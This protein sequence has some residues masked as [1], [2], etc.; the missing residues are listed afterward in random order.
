VLLELMPGRRWVALLTA[1]LVF[2]HPTLFILVYENLAQVMLYAVFVVGA[3]LCFVRIE[4][5]QRPVA[6]AV[7]AVLLYAGALTCREQSFALPGLFVGWWALGLLFQREFTRPRKLQGA[8]IAASAVL[9]A[10][11]W[12]LHIVTMK[13]FTG[14]YRNVFDAQAVLRNLTVLPQ[15]L[16]RW[17]GSEQS[18][19]LVRPN[20]GDFDLAVAIALLALTVPGLVV[21]LV[22]EKRKAWKPFLQL[23][24]WT[25]VF[26]AIPVYSGGEVWHLI[27]PVLSFSALAAWGFSVLMRER[28]AAFIA[29]AVAML[30]VG[31]KQ[32]TAQ[33]EDA[34]F[35]LYQMNAEA[36]LNPPIAREHMPRGA[37]VFYEAN[38][39]VDW[40]VG[41]GHLFGFAY[42]DP[43][44]DDRG[45]NSA[46]LTPAEVRRWLTAPHAYYFRYQ[47]AQW[48]DHTAE[49]RGQF[50]LEAISELSQR[51]EEALALMRAFDPA[52]L[53]TT[54]RRLPASR[55]R[56]VLALQSEETRQALLARLPPE[57]ASALSGTTGHAVTLEP[58][59][60][61][62]PGLE[63]S[64]SGGRASCTRLERGGEQ[65]WRITAE[66]DLKW[67]LVVLH[68]T[69]EGV[70]P[71]GGEVVVTAVMR[72]EEKERLVVQF[73]DFEA[74][75]WSLKDRA[76]KPDGAWQA[77]S[78]WRR[79]PRWNAEDYTAA[80]L[81]PVNKGQSFELKALSLSEPGTR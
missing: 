22:K 40:H 51:P 73:F 4:S 6:A 53:A 72:A 15:W 24:G 71:E 54:L 17:F 76:V 63:I 49:F 30:A 10:L 62:C 20:A 19:Y 69:P 41:G 27:L 78:V 23:V 1:V 44:L 46:E 2:S 32:F 13:S 38:G 61:D 80:G 3:A 14:G 26:T 64:T 58:S 70:P 55:A 11:Y 52:Y 8:V 29:L 18:S 48:V 31:A 65:F 56:A 5:S 37:L 45:V 77:L 50:A 9:S 67:M 36:V 66:E 59:A 42:L 25:V 39:L 68:P 16:V 21:V 74:G 33:F 28:P 47:N 12:K 7:G 60:V 81:A 43:T 79:I 57:V 75:V 35:W 34:R